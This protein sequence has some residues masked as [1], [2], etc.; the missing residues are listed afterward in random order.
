[1]GDDVIPNLRNLRPLEMASKKL[2]TTFLGIST[3]ETINSC[4]ETKMIMK[5]PREHFSYIW[6]RTNTPLCVV[7]G[8]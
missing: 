3:I 5:F 1:M 7:R 6:P 8:D 4:E 2:R